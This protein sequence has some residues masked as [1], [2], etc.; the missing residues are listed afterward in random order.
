MNRPIH[1]RRQFVRHAVVGGAALLV[2]AMLDRKGAEAARSWCRADPD[3]LLERTFVRVEVAVPEEFLPLVN[4]PAWLR[5]NLP[6]GVDRELIW[7]DAGLNGYGYDVNF[8]TAYQPNKHVKKFSVNLM[9]QVPI[10][11]G[12]KV[13]I[14][15]CA[16]PANGTYVER[17]GNDAMTGTTL[18]F[19]VFGTA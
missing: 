16:S 14:W 18:N 1:S 3:V 11:D 7:T 15:C 13:P 8:S 10:S 2:P 4:G 6:S 5:F 9:I 12:T 19:K 17:T